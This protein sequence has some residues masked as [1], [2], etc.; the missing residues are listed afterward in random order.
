MTKFL[1][2]TRR[3]AG[4]VASA[5]V[6][7]AFTPAEARPLR[8]VVPVF[9]GACNGAPPVGVTRL[10]RGHFTG[11]RTANHWDGYRHLT[12]NFDWTDQTRCFSTRAR[13]DVWLS[14]MRRAY[15]RIERYWTCLPLR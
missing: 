2:R 5:L 12:N 4:L 6:L 9:E 3:A 14:S 7:M 11:G 8:V 1:D 10:W 13:C 15:G